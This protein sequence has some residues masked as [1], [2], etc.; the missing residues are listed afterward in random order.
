M[1]LSCVLF[2]NYIFYVFL[3]FYVIYIYIL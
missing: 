1:L 3:G 2:Y